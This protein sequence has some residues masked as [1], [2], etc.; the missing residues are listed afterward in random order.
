[1]PDSLVISMHIKQA[2]G[3][4]SRPISETFQHEAILQTPS[5]PDMAG[6]PQ[7][8]LSLASHDWQLQVFLNISLCADV[9]ITS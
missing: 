9:T 4:G 5:R 3:R 6:E 2:K 7:S 1:M 8:W